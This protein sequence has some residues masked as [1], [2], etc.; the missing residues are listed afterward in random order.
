VTPISSV[1]YAAGGA[2]IGAVATRVELLPDVVDLTFVLTTAG[3]G[4]L[5][6][7]AIGALARFD[8]DRLGRIALFGQ[9]VGALVGLLIVI[10][11]VLLG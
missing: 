5:T 8:P 11:G 9:L 2:A 4:G 10:G 3:T 7:T 6:L 1:L